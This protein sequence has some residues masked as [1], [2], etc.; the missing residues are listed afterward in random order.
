[1]L[2]NYIDS[3]PI[4]Y[5]ILK[6]AIYNDKISHAYLFELNGN[7]NG[8][9]IA[10]SFA[11]SILCPNKFTN[12]NQCEGCKQCQNIDKNCFLEFKIIEPDGQWIKKEQLDNLQK[13]F[14]FKSVIGK[15]K[16]Y[17]INGADKLNTSSANTLLKFLEE[18]EEN[19][20]AILITN[21]IYQVLETIV[22]RCQIISLRQELMDKDSIIETIKTYTSIPENVTEEKLELLLQ[23]IE[24]FIYCVETQKEKAL[25]FTHKFWHDI[26]TGKE[27]SILGYDLIFLYY[28]DLLNYKLSRKQLIFHNSEKMDKMSLMS[29]TEQLDGKLKQILSIKENIKYN[30]NLNL[31][32]DRFILEMTR[33]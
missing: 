9:E 29:S 8:F 1:M 14:S 23:N 12:S 11:K 27:M 24:D 4:V 30:A 32:L 2:D 3:Q 33:C 19:I 10:K 7:F 25:L 15:Y 21:N 6:N 22:S 26:I 20:I 17:I 31:L 16:V 13:E 28:K 5:K 18:P